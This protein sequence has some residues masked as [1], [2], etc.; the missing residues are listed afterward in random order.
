MMRGAGVLLAVAGVVQAHGGGHHDHEHHDRHHEPR[1][2]I[3]LEEDIHLL[4]LDNGFTHECIHDHMLKFQDGIGKVNVTYASDMPS[5]R[6]QPKA[7]QNMRIKWFWGEDG[8]IPA[9]GNPTKNC[10]CKFNG[11]QVPDF[12]GALVGCNAQ[13][14]VDA[15]LKNYISQVM[16]S[17]AQWI[18]SAFSVER[19]VGNL[20]TGDMIVNGFA[21]P[22]A[23]P[24]CGRSSWKDQGVQTMASH[25]TT[26]VSDADFLVYVSAVPTSGNTVA[27]ALT[28]MSDQRDRPTAAHVNF[29]PTRLDP[30]V[31]VGS[32]SYNNY[33][34][35]AVHE[36]FHALGFSSGHWNGKQYWFEAH[37]A[38]QGTTNCKPTISVSERG[39]ASVTKMATPEVMTKLREYSGCNSLNGAEIENEGGSGTAGSHWEKRVFGNEA[40]TGVSGSHEAEWSAMTLAYFKDTGHYDV[41][42]AKVSKDFSWGKNK[43]CSF[44]LDKCNEISPASARSPEWCFPSDPTQEMPGCDFGLTSTGKCDVNTYG[45]CLDAQFQ[46]FSG[47]QYGASQSG[48]TDFCPKFSGY[49]NTGCTDPNDARTG[50]VTDADLGQVR[51]DNSRCFESNIMASASRYTIG[52]GELRCFEVVCAPDCLSYTIKLPNG[53][54]IP[55]TAAG[56]PTYPGSFSTNWRDQAGSGAGYITC[57]P[58]SDMCGDG[59]RAKLGAVCGGAPPTVSPS[60]PPSSSPQK[61]PTKSP[62]APPTKSPEAPPS[63]SPST[64]PQL[65]PTK[66]PEA[67]PTKSPEASPSKSPST[68]PQLPPTKSP[69]KAPT[70]SPSASPSKSPEPAPT[71]HPL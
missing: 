47:C 36:I 8:C 9:R 21:D 34:A 15:T 17:A 44:W 50:G 54:E 40:M 29:G 1:K 39:Q 31:A 69:Q 64:S 70:T 30:S 66:S 33:V 57:W 24:F 14:V 4:E 26:G 7:F 53:D 51:K 23:T 13:Q 49:S 3:P 38:A 48:L 11:D 61:S 5:R 55:C 20:K 43:G 32:I 2:L 45:S 41:D 12:Q 62:E 58:V 27:W 6:G 52:G 46:Y 16:D 10:W 71:K 37:C 68:S 65:P 67:P 18:E 59:A 60:A 56:T 35:T 28:C 19:V 42:Y 25:H 63:K 22:A